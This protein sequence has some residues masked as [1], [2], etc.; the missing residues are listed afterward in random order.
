MKGPMYHWGSQKSQH[1]PTIGGEIS[2]QANIKCGKCYAMRITE[3]D[4]RTKQ[5]LPA[6][7]VCVYMWQWWWRSEKAPKVSLVVRRKREGS[8]TPGGEESRCKGPERER[9]LR[10]DLDHESSV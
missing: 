5:M 1:G 9:D 4:R 2:K 10:A 6:Q 3:R 7:Y 8:R